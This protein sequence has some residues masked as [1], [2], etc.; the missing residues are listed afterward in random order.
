MEGIR[1]YFDGTYLLHKTWSYAKTFSHDK[2][3]SNPMDQD[4]MDVDIKKAYIDGKLCFISSH[5]VL[6]RIIP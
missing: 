6:T 4:A 2:Y 3:G 5:A 1:K